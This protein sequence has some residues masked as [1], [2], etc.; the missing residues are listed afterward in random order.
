MINI[1]VRGFWGPRKESPRELADRWLDFLARLKEVD[2]EVFADWR[3]TAGAGPQAPRAALDPEGFAAYI[4]RGD[5]DPD[6]YPVGYR[7]SLWTQREGRPKAEIGVS[8]GGVAD[9][10]PQSVVLK[11]RSRD[12]D[13]DDPL[14][15]RLPRA[16]AALADA[17][18]TDWGDFADRALMSAVREAFDLDNAGPRCGRAV[19]LSAG[20]AALVPEGLPGRRLPVAHG[21]VVVDLSGPGGEAPGTDLVLSVNETLRGTGALAPLPLPM[22]RPKL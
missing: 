22:D 3:E 13:E 8:A 19:H 12:A 4:V 6:A 2:E 11:L 7:T 16:L 17:W 1:T 10:V 15:G 20:R 9:G 5:P 21:G 14:V 18:D